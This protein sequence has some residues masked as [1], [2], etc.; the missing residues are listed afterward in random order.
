LIKPI[1]MP[2]TRAFDRH[3]RVPQRQ[4]RIRRTDAIDDESRWKL[5]M[6][7][8]TRIVYGLLDRR[9]IDQSRSASSP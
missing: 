5:E 6:S 8:T 3:A 2:A 9:I 1:A 7:D 4:R